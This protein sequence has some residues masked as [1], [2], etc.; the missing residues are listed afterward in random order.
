[1]L[2]RFEKEPIIDRDGEGAFFELEEFEKTHGRM[3]KKVLLHPHGNGRVLAAKCLFDWHGGGPGE[4]T[5]GEGGAMCLFDHPAKRSCTVINR[6][7]AAFYA[8]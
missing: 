3:M 5:P 8:P 1:M 2:L 7:C 4:I 6:R